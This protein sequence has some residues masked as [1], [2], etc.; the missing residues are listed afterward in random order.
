MKIISFHYTCLLH[1]FAAFDAVDDVGYAGVGQEIEHVFAL[2]PG[3][4]QSFVAHVSEVVR[5]QRLLNLEHFLQLAHRKLF[6]LFQQIDDAD[7]HRVRHAFKHVGRP[8]Q[9]FLVYPYF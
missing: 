8:F 1:R 9:L 4:H 7:A 6:F 5:K 2:P 3:F